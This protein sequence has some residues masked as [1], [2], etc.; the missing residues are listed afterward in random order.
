[1]GSQP[2]AGGVDEYVA[3]GDLHRAF[4]GK[5]LRRAGGVFGDDA[6]KF[7]AAFAVAV[8][9]GD[10]LRAGERALH[11]DGLARAARAEQD[12]LLSLDGRALHLHGLDKALAV[13]VLADVAAVFLVHGVHRA[14]DARRLAHAVQ[15]GDDPHLVGHGEVEALHVDGARAGNG[16]AQ[17]LG[18]HLRGDVAVVEALG[19]KARLLHHARGVVVHGVAEYAD[20]LGAVIPGHTILSLCHR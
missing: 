20:Q 17:R 12:D 7:L 9:D 3:L 16:R 15:E 5:V 2:H 19:A 8:D 4:P 14:D 13:G 6:R 11:A 10:V 18:L 1:M